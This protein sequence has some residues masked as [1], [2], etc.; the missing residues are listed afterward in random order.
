MSVAGQ[1]LIAAP[2][3]GTRPTHALPASARRPRRP[4]R[5]STFWAVLEEIPRPLQIGL[6]LVSVL[7][8]LLLWEALHLSGAVDRIFLPGPDAVVRA[9]V[10]MVSSGVLLDDTLASVQRIALGFG[11]AVLISVPLG[12]AMG[13]FRSV[14]ALFEPMIGLIRYMPA[15]AFVTLLL[16]WLGLGEPP[17]VALIVIGTVFFNTLMTA[18]VVW[19][20]PRELI[21]VSFTLGAGGFTVFRKV[22]FPYAVP[23]M[24]DSMRVNLAAAWNLIVV[25][26]VLAADRGL[27][28]RIVRAQRFLHI[29]QIFVVLATIGILGLAS[30]VALRRLRDRLAPWAQS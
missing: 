17:K 28:Y 10:D 24:I 23:G 6:T 5:R 7:T 9:A 27:G 20:L 15:T 18:N 13:T 26:E 11:I 14:Q 3:A 2:A 30:D 4:L 29:E 8:P 16:I 25:A 1:D 21:K 19:Q 12:L 22:I